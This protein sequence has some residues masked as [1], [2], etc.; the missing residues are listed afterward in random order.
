MSF[1]T[2]DIFDD[3]L[4]KA[5]N[6]LNLHRKN[7]YTVYGTE[8]ANYLRTILCDTYDEHLKSMVQLETYVASNP[9][10][11]KQLTDMLGGYPSNYLNQY[12]LNLY[13][14]KISTERFKLEYNS[15]SNSLFCYMGWLMRVERD[16]PVLH[17][18]KPHI[19]II[20]ERKKGVHL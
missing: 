5:V 20:V 10:H 19:P 7:I 13:D 15:N 17:T 9:L 6:E 4:K 8:C 11:L 12:C 2:Q 18:N 16:E 14:A 3:A 1:F